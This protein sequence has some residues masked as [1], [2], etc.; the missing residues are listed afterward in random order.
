M[1]AGELL[2]HWFATTTTQQ[3]EFNIDASFFLFCQTS[4]QRGRFSVGGGPDGSLVG[5]LCRNTN[6]LLSA[7]TPPSC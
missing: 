6:D 7:L 3:F 4:F 5:I 2:L 1:H